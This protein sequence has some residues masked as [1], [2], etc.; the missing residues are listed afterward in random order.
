MAP[1]GAP[2]AAL[3]QPRHHHLPYTGR[4]NGG[5]LDPATPAGHALPRCL[6]RSPTVTTSLYAGRET[7][8][9]TTTTLASCYSASPPLVHLLSLPSPLMLSA[10]PVMAGL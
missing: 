2:R 3:P 8:V 10:L 9:A 7:V 6:R 4:P 1:R 5:L